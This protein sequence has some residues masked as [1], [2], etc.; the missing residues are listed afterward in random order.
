MC[1]W[2][3]C[4]VSK[5]FCTHKKRARFARRSGFSFTSLSLLP[6][7]TT[8]ES[9]AKAK[10]GADEAERRLESAL[11]EM[12]FAKAQAVEA[13]KE[14]EAAHSAEYIAHLELLATGAEP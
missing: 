3:E 11:T 13:D 6:W 12:C 5:V 1:A 14:E 2:L 9:E 8:Q 7:L 4:L 10:K